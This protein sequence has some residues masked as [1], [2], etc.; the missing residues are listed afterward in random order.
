[1][2]QRSSS[3]GRASRKRPS[4]FS[5][6]QALVVVVHAREGVSCEN[7]LTLRGAGA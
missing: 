1:M 2:P 5:I 7:P 3:R 4:V 6:G